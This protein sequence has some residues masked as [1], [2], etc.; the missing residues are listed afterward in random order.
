MAQNMLQGK[1]GAMRSAA[2]M[3]GVLLFS[4]LSS[5][6]A[7]Y[8][9][10]FPG[11]GDPFWSD[12]G[13]GSQAVWSASSPGSVSSYYDRFI[14]AAAPM[15]TSAPFIVGDQFRL[16]GTYALQ[17]SSALGQLFFLPSSFSFFGFAISNDDDLGLDL[18]R[19]WVGNGGPPVV[20]GLVG[21]D[22]GGSFDF[23]VNAAG[24]ASI[25]YDVY[26]A[27]GSGGQLTM[28]GTISDSSGP[29]Y[30]FA[31]NFFITALASPPDNIG[32]VIIASDMIATDDNTQGP[33][34]LIADPINRL[35]WGYS[36]VPE[37]TTAMLFGLGIAALAWA[38][39]RRGLPRS[40]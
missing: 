5:G 36:M 27:L 34:Q 31:T 32:A 4:V 20:T 23:D 21:V 28:S 13:S 8:V 18:I 10:S 14:G 39:G 3:V 35:E 33:P 24:V 12:M 11:S 17:P 2:R 38:R 40:P 22:V 7:E 16:S 29:R 30:T 6:R 19:L 37:P 15:V 25:D 26:F 1:E 9:L